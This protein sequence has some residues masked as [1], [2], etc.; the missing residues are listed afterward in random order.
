MLNVSRHV[1]RSFAPNYPEFPDSCLFFQLTARKN[2]GQVLTDR[3]H[4]HIKQLAHLPL[5]QPH[6]LAFHTY[7]DACLPLNR[8]IDDDRLLCPVFTHSAIVAQHK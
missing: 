7:I 1:P 4:V 5:A 8:L 6:R 3:T 2:V